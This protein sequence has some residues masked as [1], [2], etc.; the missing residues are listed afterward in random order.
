[1]GGIGTSMIENKIKTDGNGEKRS[2]NS[3]KFD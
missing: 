2:G 1:V 3:L